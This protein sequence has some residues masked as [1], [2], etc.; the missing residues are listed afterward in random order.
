MSSNKKNQNFN[1]YAVRVGKR[2][3]IFRSWILASPEVIGW[4]KAQYKGFD[5]LD[6]A[7]YYMNLAGISDP[8]IIGEKDQI[9][10]VKQ[11]VTSTEVRSRSELESEHSTIPKLLFTSTQSPKQPYDSLDLEDEDIFDKTVVKSKSYAAA[12]KF[13]S[14]STTTNLTLDFPNQKPNECIC[15]KKLQQKSLRCAVCNRKVHWCCTNL[16]LYQLTMFIKTTRKFTCEQCAQPMIDDRCQEE[17]ELAKE[18]AQI[19]FPNVNDCSEVNVIK[20][21]SK[22][23]GPNIHP[24]EPKYPL[25]KLSSIESAQVKTNTLLDKIESAINNLAD[26]HIN[27]TTQANKIQGQ[28]NKL[29]VSHRSLITEFKTINPPKQAHPLKVEKVTS[30]KSKLQ[31]KAQNNW[32]DIEVLSSETLDSNESRSRAKSNSTNVVADNENTVPKQYTRAH[33]NDQSISLIE[34]SSKTELDTES[35]GESFVTMSEWEENDKYLSTKEN[36]EPITHIFHDSILNGVL[37]EKVE[38]SHDIQIENHKAST[39][40]DCENQIKKINHG[41]NIHIL[42]H[43]GLNDL[44]HRSPDETSRQMINMINDIDENTKVVI[45]NV[46]LSNNTELDAKC[47]LHNALVYS[48][49]NQKQNVSFIKNE[50]I[51]SPRF[52]LSNDGI[53]PNR[54]GASILAF[55]IGKHVRW[56]EG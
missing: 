33:Q 32:D 49:L 20:S 25:E 13:R 5:K 8:A 1:Y 43:C 18:E 37:F 38:K 50:N 44:K 35:I 17:F 6:D 19:N 56:L 28:I 2:T 7:K 48:A 39:L 51:S 21:T 34:E 9:Q 11:N 26:M 45:S 4:P 41:P 53:H 52:H 30:Q 29:D 12:A 22:S 10:S 3:G 14:S 24:S 27:L 47:S 40:K 36:S 31:N 55:N 15:N 54:K 16:P 46:I 42:V 23:E